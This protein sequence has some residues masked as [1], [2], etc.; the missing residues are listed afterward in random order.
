MNLVTTKYVGELRARSEVEGR[1]FT[2]MFTWMYPRE[3][4]QNRI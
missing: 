2:W 1:L 4:K 3:S